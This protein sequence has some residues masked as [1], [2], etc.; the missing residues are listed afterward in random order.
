MSTLK[1]NPADLLKDRFTS[2][3]KKLF[4]ERS[5][6][7]DVIDV[8][9]FEHEG[10]FPARLYAEWA[11]CNPG[12]RDTLVFRVVNDVLELMRLETSGK[13]M[14]YTRQEVSRFAFYA[15]QSLNRVVQAVSRYRA[16]DP[17]TRGEL[18]IP[19]VYTLRGGDVDRMAMPMGPYWVLHQFTVTAKHFEDTHAKSPRGIHALGPVWTFPQR[20]GTVRVHAYMPCDQKLTRIWSEFTDY[21]NERRDHLIYDDLHSYG[22]FTHPS[23]RMPYRGDELAW[24]LGSY[25]WRDAA[26]GELTFVD[27]NA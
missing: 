9:N 20:D 7:E 15:W 2:G 27:I 1:F 21:K 23:I 18:T 3:L 17:A 6:E 4:Q 11:K 25:Y 8:E 5:S 13:Q 19:T 22:P 16:S 26:T 10:A 24:Q 14:E 12:S